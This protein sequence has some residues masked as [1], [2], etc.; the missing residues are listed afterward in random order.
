MHMTPGRG[1]AQNE[2]CNAPIAPLHI[3]GRKR[4]CC[5]SAATSYLATLA[6]ALGDK[7]LPPSLG[8]QPAPPSGP[9]PYIVQELEF[10]A[11]LFQR[12]EAAIRGE[13]DVLAAAGISLDPVAAMAVQAYLVRLS[14]CAK[15]RALESQEA[16]ANGL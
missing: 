1:Q 10:A 8:H 14:A 7:E 12:A 11:D 5:L 2:K 13:L 16:R 9:S 3:Y 4:R 6:A 15:I